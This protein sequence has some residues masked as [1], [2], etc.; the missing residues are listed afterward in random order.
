MAG[1]LSQDN[2][3]GTLQT[4]LG[5]DV[6]VLSRFNCG[7]GLGELFQ[8]QIEALSEQANIDFDQLLG[9]NLSITINT[10]DQLKRYFNGALVRARWT[11]V[12]NDLFVY[13]LTVMPWLWLLS[14]TADC[15]I[16]K[17]MSVPDI[18]A[19]VFSD[20]GYSD[21]RRELTNSYPALE[22]CVQYRES[23]MNFV[24]RLMEEYGI[25]YFFEHTQDKHIL[26]LAEFENKPQ[27]GSRSGAGAL[28]A[29]DQRGTTAREAA[30]RPLGDSSRLPKWTLRAERL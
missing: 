5:K 27:T 8:Y 12:R 6:L 18:I 13:E 17:S 25:Y 2:R 1:D 20:S 11:G 21:Y 28:P 10:V 4:P 23:D 19:E 3:A 15:R 30:I 14:H 24:C 9:R 26:V 16:F 22:Y 29:L 7:E